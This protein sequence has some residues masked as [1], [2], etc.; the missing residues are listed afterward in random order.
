MLIDVV[1][2][3]EGWPISCLLPLHIFLPLAPPSLVED[4]GWRTECNL[5]ERLVRQRDG[6][7]KGHG[8]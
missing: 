6:L 2:R 1:G 4:G 5:K 8:R 7:E 3:V